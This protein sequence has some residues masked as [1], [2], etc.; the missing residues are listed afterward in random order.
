MSDDARTYEW[1]EVGAFAHQH[2]KSA[3]TIRRWVR[4]HDLPHVRLGARILIRAD[5]LDALL[6]DLYTRQR[7]G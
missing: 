3:S 5:A 7:G 1:L 2:G 4:Q 6:N